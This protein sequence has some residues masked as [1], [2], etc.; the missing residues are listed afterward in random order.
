MYMMLLET[1][2]LIYSF[3]I[4]I[5]PVPLPQSTT[6]LIG[7]LPGLIDSAKNLAY[8]S[9][10]SKCSIL[11]LPDLILKCLSNILR[12]SLD[13][14]F[15]LLYSLYSIYKKEGVQHDTSRRNIIGA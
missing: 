2:T 7:S 12:F 14:Y 3:L 4:I 15:N 1:T 13:F 10:I 5:E 8:E 11:P 9:V 6:A